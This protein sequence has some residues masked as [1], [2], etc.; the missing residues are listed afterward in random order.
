MLERIFLNIFRSHDD[1]KRTLTGQM[2]ENHAIDIC[3]AFVLIV[4]KFLS[5]HTGRDKTLKLNRGN[6]N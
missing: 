1:H 4:T 2:E 5:F 6:G 3:N